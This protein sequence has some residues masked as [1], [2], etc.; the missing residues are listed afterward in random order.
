MRRETEPDRLTHLP[1]QELLEE[2]GPSRPRV[3]QILREVAL[4]LL[5]ARLVVDTAQWPR[6]S[7]NDGFA[8]EFLTATLGKPRQ[9][10]DA[11]SLLGAYALETLQSINNRAHSWSTTKGGAKYRSAVIRA[12]GGEFCSLCGR[13]EGLAVDHI[14]PVSVGGPSDAVPNMQLLCQEC[15]HGKGSLRDRLLPA[16]LSLRTARAIS[17]GLRFKHLLLDSIQVGGRTR[18][19][20]SC[21]RQAD[22]VELRV[23]VEPGAA[24]ANLLTLTTRCSH[25]EQEPDGDY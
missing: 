12:Q 1:L 6:V 24:A 14:V 11:E 8:K 4:G 19:V 25:C 22:S 23:E 18:G 16:A 21:G 15:N 10:W 7:G 13:R 2:A 17:A 5:E 20:C 3:E 9:S